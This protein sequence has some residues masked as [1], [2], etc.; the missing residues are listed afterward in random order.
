MNVLVNYFEKRF[1]IGS[2][3]DL[4]YPK[5]FGLLQEPGK[6]N[7]SYNPSRV[8]FSHYF[9]LYA[10]RA[11]AWKAG[12]DLYKYNFF[13]GQLKKVYLPQHLTRNIDLFFSHGQY[14]VGLRK[15]GI[16]VLTNTGFMT[17][18]FLQISRDEDRWDEVHKL[19]KMSSLATLITFSSQDAIERF[20]TFVPSMRPKIRVAPFLIPPIGPLREEE[21]Y[22]KQF[23]SK[24][25]IAFIGTE[26][27]RKGIDNLLKAIRNIYVANSALLLNCE[28][29]FVTKDEVSLPAQI[30]YKHDTVLPNEEVKKILREAAIF[31]MP[32]TKESYGIV[33][34]EAMG[35]G[36]AILCDDQMPRKEIFKNNLAVFT[37]PKSVPSIEAGLIKLI[38]DPGYRFELAQKSYRHFSQQYAFDVVS[39]Y[40]RELFKETISIA[41]S[42]TIKYDAQ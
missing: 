17:N 25:K 5:T 12:V 28:F 42:D 35:N 27:K 24:V 41:K 23:A 29:H 9:L 14:P 19:C 38:T 21:I 31:A 15:K 40:Y 36:C 30:V 4:N 7:I 1:I 18:D 13:Y 3:T 39:E 34:I 26:G 20:C 37:D 22:K 11:M 10:I 32:T 2:N 6:I 8:S 33:Y 16:P